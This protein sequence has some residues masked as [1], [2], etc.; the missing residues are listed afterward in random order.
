MVEAITMIIPR[1]ERWVAGEQPTEVHFNKV[2]DLISFIQNPPE[3]HVVQRGTPQSIPNGVWTAITFTHAIR[4]TEAQYDAANPMWS[5]ANPTR[6]YIRTAGWYSIEVFTSFASS[7]DN[8]RRIQALGLNGNMT[9][10]DMRGRFDSRNTSA[11]KNRSAYD[12]FLEPGTYVELGVYQ[13]RG[14]ALSLNDPGY[15]GGRTSVRMK[16]SSH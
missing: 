1:V 2:K 16:W 6:I 5:V 8:N 13:D 7:A 15:D 12:I 14:S 4:D 3:V 9:G 10:T 11:H